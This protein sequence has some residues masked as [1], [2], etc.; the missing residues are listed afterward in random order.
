MHI[1]SL[2]LVHLLAIAALSYLL[3]Y[4]CAQMQFAASPDERKLPPK[5][6]W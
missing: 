2:L 5:D 6:T 1:D 3:G 4:L